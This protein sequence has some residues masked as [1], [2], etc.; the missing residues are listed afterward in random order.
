[1]TKLLL[2]LML[3]FFLSTGF[4]QSFKTV[5]T[6]EVIGLLESESDSLFV[7]NFWATW[8]MPCVKE[9]P[10]FEAVSKKYKNQKI[11]LILV[12]LD[13]RQD[14]DKKLI[15]FLEKHKLVS[16]VWFLNESNPNIFIPKIENNW[17]G[18]IPFTLFVRGSTGVKDYFEG[19]L[20]QDGL[21]QR[22]LKALK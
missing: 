13:F 7:V 18:A 20:T 2:S 1:M 15:P 11:K 5:N 8:C 6:D 12:S 10:Y 4:G 17:S 9:I 14:I 16:E 19:S 3:G 22:I 21:E